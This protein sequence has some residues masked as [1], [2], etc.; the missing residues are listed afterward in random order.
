[1]GLKFDGLALEICHV[2]RVFELEVLGI[3]DCVFYKFID[4]FC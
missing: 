3:D 1:M 4:V 2:G